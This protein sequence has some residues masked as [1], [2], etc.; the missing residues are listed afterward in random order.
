MRVQALILNKSKIV[1]DGVKSGV[2][3]TTERL[4]HELSCGI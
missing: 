3:M 1:K 2:S 4:A